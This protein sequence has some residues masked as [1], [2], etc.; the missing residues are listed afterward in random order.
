MKI[1]ESI[2]QFV[3]YETSMNTEEFIVQWEKFTKRFLSKGIEVSLQEQA[4]GKNKFKFV[5]RN[6]WPQDSFQFVFMEGRL[7]HNFPEGHVKVIE[8]GGY[9]PLQIECNRAKP[10]TIKMLVFAKSPQLDITALKNI[11]GYKHLN[12]YEAYYESCK[13]AFI[14]EYFIKESQLDTFRE[15]LNGQGILAEIGVY[16]ECGMVAV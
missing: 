13:Y 12:I 10:D 2:V 3:S 7:S 5:S 4:M 6:V 16:R 11:P 15:Q 1:E 14:F 9:T 8:A